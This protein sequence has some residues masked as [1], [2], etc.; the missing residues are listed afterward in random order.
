MPIII[1]DMRRNL[2]LCTFI[3]WYQS[4][5]PGTNYFLIV[6]ELRKNFIWKLTCLKWLVFGIYRF[7]YYGHDFGKGRNF[8]LCPL[9][10]LPLIEIFI[11][12]FTTFS[13]RHHVAVGI[14]FLCRNSSFQIQIT[15]KL[16]LIMHDKDSKHFVLLLQQRQKRIAW[17]DKLSKVFI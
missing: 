4:R 3:I 10:L 13:C 5:W 2:W 12:N 14:F 7:W 16:F 9:C 15:F 8:K 6:S 17:H 11:C 1:Y